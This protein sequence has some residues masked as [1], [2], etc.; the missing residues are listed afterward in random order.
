MRYIREL[1]PYMYWLGY[2]DSGRQA[3]ELDWKAIG[4]TWGCA[5][6]NLGSWTR[7]PSLE[8]PGS[9]L[10]SVVNRVGR[11]SPILGKYIE[12]YFA[13]TLQ[14]IRS[15]NRVL[16]SGATAHY[17]IGNSKFYETVLPTE[18]IYARILESE[19]FADVEVTPI[20]KRTSKKELFEFV[21]SATKS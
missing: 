14:H 12:K 5:T 17:I 3:G 15:L 4:G 18:S 16:H 19:G 2:L 21:V 13:D 11:R 20:R 10:S 6:S 9:I 8:M 1:R 7:D